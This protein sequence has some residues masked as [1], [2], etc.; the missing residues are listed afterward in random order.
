M[1]AVG[2]YLL[3]TRSSQECYAANPQDASARD[4]ATYA[5][6]RAFDVIEAKH[7]HDWKQPLIVPVP[8]GALTLT[9]R[10]DPDPDWHPSLY[11]FASSDRYAGKITQEQSRS[12]RSG[13][14]AP[15][16]ASV[17]AQAARIHNP[18]A[19]E[20]IYYGVTAVARF[21]Q[22]R[23]EIS[24]EDPL[25][26]ENIRLEGRNL[27][28]AADFTTPLA[29]ML[30]DH[31][32]LRMGIGR[33]LKPGKFAETARITRLQPYDPDKTIVL[34]IHGLA[35]EPA[36]WIPMINALRGDAEIRQRYQFWFYS[37]PSG[38][39][40]P[41]SAAVLRAEL[42]KV[43]STLRP[44]QPMVVIG[45]SMGGCISR[46]L[47]T[48]TQGDS[49]WRKIFDKSPKETNLSPKNQRL[50]ADALIFRPRPEVGRVVFICAP[51]QGSEMATTN[52]AQ[53]ASKL[54]KAPSTLL[55][56][57]DELLA[58]ITEGRD[59]GRL[60][61]IPNSVDTLSPDNRFVKA[62]NTFPVCSHVPHHVICGDRG[63]GGNKARVEPMMSDGIVA[64]WSSR[65]ESAASE[66]IV[67][68]DHSAQR[69]QATIEEVVRILKLH[70]AR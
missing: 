70:A 54:I 21:Q 3:A 15:L 1:E 9:H 56:A 66:K 37:Y 10:V 45:H 7:L 50:F 30:E 14:G 38:W 64:Y 47:I 57:G 4:L 34:C 67:P 22:G 44:R 58:N 2:R 55:A 63:E 42:D 25:A 48:D 65:M 27:P 26:L 19:G 62:I 69:R 32:S 52:L 36:T 28:L 35:S 40:Y 18:L 43:A 39:P 20:R 41:H 29:F 13:V 68:H 46:L 6:S 51:L 8:G 12:A 59:G 31:N 24:F 16:V 23:C 5:L 60:K 61:Q 33:L 17:S 49:L 11:D 53:L